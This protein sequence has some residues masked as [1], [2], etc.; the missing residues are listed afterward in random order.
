MGDTLGV[1]GVRGRMRSLV[2]ECECEAGTRSP[3]TNKAIGTRQRP[4]TDHDSRSWFLINSF[5][6]AW[7]HQNVARVRRSLLETSGLLSDFRACLLTSGS[8]QLWRAV[9]SVNTTASAPPRRVSHA[10]TPIFSASRQPRLAE[11]E[12]DHD[13]LVRCSR[14]QLEGPESERLES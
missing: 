6:Q 8:T 12:A 1:G 4:N 11:R 2:S 3:E 9:T 14:G 13:C 5:T 10:P 7:P